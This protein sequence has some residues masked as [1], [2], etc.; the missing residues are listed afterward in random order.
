MVGAD[1]ISSLCYP[2][3]LSRIPP[4]SG[5]APV[6]AL[7]GAALAAVW[8]L[9]WSC[10]T[11]CQESQWGGRAVPGMLGLAAF[12]QHGVRGLDAVLGKFTSFQMQ[13]M[14]FFSLKTCG[15]LSKMPHTWSLQP[16]ETAKSWKLGNCRFWSIRNSQPLSNRCCL[17]Q[18]RSQS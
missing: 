10:V 8:S 5:L 15:C 2:F 4:T 1:S 16:Q 9:R 11:L 7:C 18:W 12:R 17:P 6:L 13:E 14:S 3:V